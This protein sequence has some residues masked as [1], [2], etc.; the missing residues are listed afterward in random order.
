[1]AFIAVYTNNTYDDPEEIDSVIERIEVFASW[2]SVLEYAMGIAEDEAEILFDDDQQDERD[3]M[4]A[5]FRASLKCPSD[6]L[7][8]QFRIGDDDRDNQRMVTIRR[9]QVER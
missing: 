2:E 4:L 3:E 5:E 1:M 7:P 6:E 9:V 8:V